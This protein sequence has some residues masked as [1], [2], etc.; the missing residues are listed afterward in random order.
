MIEV[1]TVSDL[2]RQ[3]AFASAYSMD[4]AFKKTCVPFADYSEKCSRLVDETEGVEISLTVDGSPAAWLV[5]M[6]VEDWHHHGL[7]LEVNAVVISE[8]FR[9]YR[10]LHRAV[11]ETIHEVALAWE[12]CWIRR[13]THLNNEA[14]RVITKRLT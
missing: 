3:M 10:D 14:D 6:C 11:A 8:E 1:H 13:T 9:A 4:T 7:I 2:A 12:C 5:L